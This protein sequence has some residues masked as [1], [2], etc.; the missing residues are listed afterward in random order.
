MQGFLCAQ[1]PNIKS[2][3]LENKTANVKCKT[4]Q[5]KNRVYNV[6]TT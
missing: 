2:R 6:Y 3:D 4:Y 5:S 1:E